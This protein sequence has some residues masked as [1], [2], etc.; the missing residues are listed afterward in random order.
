MIEKVVRSGH[1]T[2]SNKTGQTDKQAYI[3]AESGFESIGV[4]NIIVGHRSPL[5][6]LHHFV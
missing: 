6:T 5:N 3:D 2:I 4:I 1:Q